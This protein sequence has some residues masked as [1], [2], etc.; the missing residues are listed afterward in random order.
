MYVETFKI[1]VI[2]FVASIKRHIVTSHRLVDTNNITQWDQR[3]ND[4]FYW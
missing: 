4:Y 1:D 3:K 2:F